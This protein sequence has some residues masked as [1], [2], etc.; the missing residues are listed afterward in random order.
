MTI[1]PLDHFLLAIYISFMR[2]FKNTFVFALLAVFLL[3]AGLIPAI[4]EPLPSDPELIARELENGLKYIIKKHSNPPGRVSLWLHVAS[5]SLNETEN[6]RGLAH[7]LEH[8]AFNG[9]A[10]FPP[11]SLVPFFQSLGLSFGR[12][13]NAFTGFQQTTYQLALPDTKTETL[14]KGMLYLSDVAMRLSLSPV[15]IG[16]ERQIILEEK[17]SRA[18]PAQRV[19]EYV[20]ERLAPESTFGRRLPIGTEKTIESFTPAQVKEYYSRWYVPSNMTL[21]IVGECDPVM[22]E[23]LIQKHFAQGPKLPR[24][25]DREVGVQSQKTTRAI[26]A[27]DPELTQADVSV[28]RVETPREPTLTVEQYRRDLVEGMGTWAFNRRI[29]AQLAEGKASFLNASVSV[30][31]E[32]NAIRLIT[33]EASGKPGEWRRMLADLGASIQRARLH[34][35]SEREVEDVTRSLLADAEEAVLREQTLPA[36]TILRR[37]NGSLARREPVTSAAQRLNIL[38]RLLPGITATEISNVF[39]ANFDPTHVTFVA[40]LPSGADVPTEAELIELGRLAL[41]VKPER[42]AEVARAGSL[43]DHVP[44]AGK[45]IDLNDHLRSGVKS[46][47]LENG[48]RFHYRH[49]DYRK[50]EATVTITLAG[51][52]IQETASNR[53]ITDV[54]VLAW[55]R[56]ATSKLSSVQIRDLMIGKKVR[57][58]GRADAD[59]LTVSVWGTPGDLE[60]GLQLAYLLLT[61]PIIERAAVDQ[62]KE[63]ERQRISSRKLQPGGVLSEAVAAAFYPLDEPRLKPLEV[64]QVERIGIESAQTWLKKILAEAPIEV[65]I[66]GDIDEPAARGL[67][68]R[69]LGSLPARD[70]ISKN[71]LA[72]L[73]KIKRSLGPIIVGRNIDVKT[74]QAF[75]MDGFFGTDIQ[76][77]RD[78]RLLAM[79][80]RILSTRMN[81]LLREE[82]QLV[83]SIGAWSQPASEYPGF[84]LFMARAPTDPAKAEALATALN[85]MYAAFGENGPTDDELAVAKK[86]VANLLDQVMKEPDFWLTRLAILDYRGLS[87]DDL[88]NGPADYQRYNAEEVREAF[89]RYNKPDARFRFVVTPGKSGGN[90][91]KSSVPKN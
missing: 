19:Q 9:S 88:I 59:T 58:G 14:D 77:V 2:K 47:W 22:V 86:Q 17:R 81:T 71:T 31:E 66:V 87:L 45:L 12:D 82:K 37:I 74:P 62:W 57:V 27:T 26:V 60:V 10:N 72:D 40:E 1:T 5:G 64:E 18:G 55:N 54:A 29:A 8:M 61:D 42:E 89:T 16:N 7:F 3:S 50:N 43:L 78:S 53:G 39:A 15:E 51:G 63:V 28:V 69:Y 46:G 84:G 6:T 67:V 4:A 33:A 21:I 41:S 79:A 32:G 85:E 34:G 13:Q 48:V 56:P 30:H 23:G 76:N 70:R 25:A 49:M 24:P 65:A 90:P 36:R 83:Y 73:R 80:A 68:E 38:K 75:V 44:V 91:E 11:G 35:F 20:Y 52:R